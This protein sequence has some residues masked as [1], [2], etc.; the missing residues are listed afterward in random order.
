[1]KTRGI[2][3]T[4]LP[5]LSQTLAGQTLGSMC[6]A[7]R[8][9]CVEHNGSDGRPIART[10]NV[11]RGYVINGTADWL[12]ICSTATIFGMKQGRDLLAVLAGR[13]GGMVSVIGAA[14][15]LHCIHV[16]VLRTVGQFDSF[17]RAYCEDSDYL[18]RHQLAGLGEVA[19]GEGNFHVAIDAHF[20]ENAH[21]IKLGLADADMPARAAARYELKWGGMPGHEVW[22]H[23]YNDD[24]RDWKWRSIDEYASGSSP[25]AMRVDLAT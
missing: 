5:W 2:A 15:H 11:A 25:D 10:W 17:D 14:W 23:P 12:I 19:K 6:P 18:W 1:M 22:L 16:D 7:M 8:S 4:A 21:S 20:R 24:R 3:V 9:L 13:D